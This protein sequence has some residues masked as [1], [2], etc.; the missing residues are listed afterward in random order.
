MLAARLVTLAVQQA[1]LAVRR[2]E[3]AAELTLVAKNAPTILFVRVSVYNFTLMRF[4]IN[5]RKMIAVKK[6]GTKTAI[7]AAL[8]LFSAGSVAAGLY[9]YGYRDV[10]KFGKVGNFLSSLFYK[11]GKNEAAKTINNQ[12]SSQLNNQIGKTLGTCQVCGGKTYCKCECPS[13]H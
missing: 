9:Y 12:I 6:I 11:N 7:T 13:K 8:L 2:A 5:M 3:L 10:S 4:K 1:V